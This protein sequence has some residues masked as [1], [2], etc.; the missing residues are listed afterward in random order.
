MR[1]PRSAPVCP[2]LMMRSGLISIC[3]LQPHIAVARLRGAEAHKV[4]P[5]KL[6]LRISAQTRIAGQHHPRPKLRDDLIAIP[7]TAN[8]ERIPPLR[9]SSDVDRIGRRR[10]VVMLVEDARSSHT[11]P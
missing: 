9:G 6:T 2:P 1:P 10:A 3:D 11:N 4:A 5:A 8:H 7:I